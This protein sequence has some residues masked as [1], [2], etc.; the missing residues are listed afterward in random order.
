MFVNIVS[1]S[2]CGEGGHKAGPLALWKGNEA[3]NVEEHTPEL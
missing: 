1:Q 2:V 3:Y